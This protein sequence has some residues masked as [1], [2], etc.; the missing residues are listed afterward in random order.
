MKSED[1]NVDKRSDG[2]EEIDSP[3]WQ[4]DE[5]RM[6]QGRRDRC[7]LKPHLPKELEPEGC[8]VEDDEL[9]EEKTIGPDRHPERWEERPMPLPFS[10]LYFQSVERERGESRSDA[11]EETDVAQEGVPAAESEGIA[12]M[13]GEEEHG[14]QDRHQSCGNAESCAEK[15]E[16]EEE[17]EREY[18]FRSGDPLEHGEVVDGTGDESGER[19]GKNAGI[20]VEFSDVAELHQEVEERG[21]APCDPHESETGGGDLPEE[22]TV[23]AGEG[24][25]EMHYV[26]RLHVVISPG[27]TVTSGFQ[28]HHQE[29]DAIRSWAGIT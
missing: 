21:Q 5:R 19:G 6:M 17:V 7:S 24:V 29:T 22:E 13:E 11:E 28:F 25:E 14:A 18:R 9:P 23:D 2:C 27:E 3:E 1:T 10:P 16:E 15:S 8:P 26:T 12:F 4:A 20:T